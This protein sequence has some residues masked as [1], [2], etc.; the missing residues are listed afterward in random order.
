MLLEVPDPVWKVSM[1]NSASSSP[2]ATR[3]A[4]VTTA[5]AISCGTTPS[6]ALTRAAAP[7]TRPSAAISAGSIGVPEIGKF[8]TARCV[9]AAKSA[10]RGTR[11]SPIVSCSM[12]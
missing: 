8:S 6:S 1:G 9:C 5:S 4:A 11:T 3:A 7:L 2:D 10:S 12:R